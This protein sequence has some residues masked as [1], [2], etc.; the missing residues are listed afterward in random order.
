MGEY[1]VALAI[2]PA[3]RPAPTIHENETCG[4]FVVAVQSN[5]WDRNVMC[6]T[7]YLIDHRTGRTCRQGAALGSLAVYEK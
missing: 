7:E 4:F 2:Q 5:V 3:V 1:I 6:E